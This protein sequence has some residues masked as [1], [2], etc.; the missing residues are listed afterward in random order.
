MP[1]GRR[2]EAATVIG[3]CL[4][5]A[6]R[7]ANCLLIQAALQGGS[8]ELEKAQA[9]MASLVEAHPTFSLEAERAYR[10]FGDKPLMEEFL[11][12]LARA[13]APRR[14]DVPARAAARKTMRAS[15][16][17]G[18]VRGL[19]QLFI[20]VQLCQT[21]LLALRVESRSGVYKE[22][23]ESLINLRRDNAAFQSGPSGPAM[24]AGGWDSTGG[25]RE[26]W[27]TSPPARAQGD[28]W[29][30]VATPDPPAGTPVPA[31]PAPSSAEGPDC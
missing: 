2:E 9:T 24:S 22:G 5:R 21:A 4:V 28:P 23:S 15:A 20:S 8:G 14:P 11:Q 26:T 7:D 25:T 1:H 19:R 31:R 27:G 13:K 12:D 16:V 10:R 30:C 29:R 17:T 18:A 3:E 6:P